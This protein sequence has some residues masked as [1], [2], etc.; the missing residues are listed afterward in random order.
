MTMVRFARG[1]K[2]KPTDRGSAFLEF[3]WAVNDVRP[4]TFGAPESRPDTPAP[5]YDTE[6]Y[7]H[8]AVIHGPGDEGIRIV[9]QSDDVAAAFRVA[10]ARLGIHIAGEPK[11]KPL[12]WESARAYA[13]SLR[14][15]YTAD[16][17]AVVIA[18]VGP[19]KALVDGNGVN[20]WFTFS[21]LFE[22]ERR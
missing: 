14:D 11:M 8:A 18:Q 13:E 5:G 17:T 20:G 1:E 4:D 2:L 21:E 12:T 16:G 22:I 15:V 10:A 9:A 3:I 6:Q 19:A 7:P